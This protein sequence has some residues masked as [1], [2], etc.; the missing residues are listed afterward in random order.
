MTGAGRSPK[1]SSHAGVVL[2]N[3]TPY[4]VGEHHHAPEIA[5]HLGFPVTFVPHLLPV[6]RGLIATCYVRSRGDDLRG[7]LE[8]HYASS[9][10]VTVL[11][12]GVVPDLA[13]V[14]QTDGVEIGI[15]EDRLT[16]GFVVI[17]ALDNLGKGAAG[18]AVQ[19][20]NLLFGFDETAGLRLSGVLV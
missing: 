12:E 6:R 11:P 1:A 14:Q 20:V 10:V 3:V 2:E 4:S 15:F 5:A 7:L 17:C 9:H 13:R 19:N 8:D 16:G 18:Q